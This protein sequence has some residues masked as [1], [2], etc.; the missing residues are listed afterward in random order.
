MRKDNEAAEKKRNPA[1][2]VPNT[3]KLNTFTLL[4]IYTLGQEHPC[5]RCNTNRQICKGYP[6]HDEQPR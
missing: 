2:P 5:D 6:R 4:A 1:D 3:C